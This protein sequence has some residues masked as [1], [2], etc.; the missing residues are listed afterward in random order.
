[1]KHISTLSYGQRLVS[2]TLTG[3]QAAVFPP[4]EKW[5][6]FRELCFAR[7][8]F[9]LSDRDLTVL[10]ALLSF[11]KGKV[12]DAAEQL[13]VFP[14]NRTLSERAHGMAE[15]TLRRHLGAL[16][17]AGIIRRQDSPNRKRYARKTHLGMV[18]LAFG[19]DLRPLLER[20]GEIADIA[21]DLRKEQAEYKLIRDEVMLLKRDAIALVE[22]FGKNQPHPKWETLQD[23]LLDLHKVSRRKLGRQALAELREKLL[24]LH[25]EISLISTG[26][27]E[28]LSGSDCQNER[29]FQISNKEEIPKTITDKSEPEMPLSQV[30]AATPDLNIYLRDGPRTWRTYHRAAGDVVPMMGINADVWAEAETVM[31]PY[32]AS[33]TLGCILQR[34]QEVRNPNAYLRALISKARKGAFSPVGMVTALLKTKGSMLGV[35]SCQLSQPVA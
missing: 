30:R 14:S 7:V 29:Q 18:A 5:P 4:V 33:I 31:G 2:P 23:T 28:K 34:I 27:T 6:L 15:S 25:R 19:F 9:G 20:A 32:Q 22:Y 1:M 10:N 12:L 3:S 11:H 35:D 17:A 24:D 8:R 16:V 26:E 13:V 21:E